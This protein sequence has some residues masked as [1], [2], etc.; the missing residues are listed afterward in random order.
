MIDR[1]K[2]SSFTENKTFNPKIGNNNN[3][4]KVSLTKTGGNIHTTNFNESK[5]L[6]LM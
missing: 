4:F 5:I 1:F 3:T 2:I 6:K